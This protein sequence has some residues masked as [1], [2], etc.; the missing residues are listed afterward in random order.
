[1]ATGIPVVATRHT[2]IADVVEH[3]TH[4]LLSDELDVGTMAAHME[5]LANDGELAARMGRSARAN[6]EQHHGVKESVGRL[7]AILENVARSTKAGPA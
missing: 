7:Q 3:G 1:M 5:L 6:M 2:G 4:G